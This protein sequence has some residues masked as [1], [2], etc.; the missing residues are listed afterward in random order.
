MTPSNQLTQLTATIPANS[1]VDV[2]NGPSDLNGQQTLP[3]G[4]GTQPVVFI[5]RRI[6]AGSV[7][8]PLRV[9]DTCGEWR[10]FVGGGNAAF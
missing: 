6:G 7:T 8:V 1:L 9:T 2:V 5:V 10:T 4:N 3:V